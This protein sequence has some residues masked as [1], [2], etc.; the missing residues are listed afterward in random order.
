M[1]RHPNGS[2]HLRQRYLAQIILNMI[3]V[4]DK[5]SSNPTTSIKPPIEKMR[6]TKQEQMTLITY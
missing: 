4:M 5:S 6:D 3:P 1:D 2:I